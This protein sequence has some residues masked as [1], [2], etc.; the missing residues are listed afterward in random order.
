MLALLRAKM[1]SCLLLAML[2]LFLSKLLDLSDTVVLLE[3]PNRRRWRR[4]GL[5]IHNLRVPQSLLKLG[6]AR[7][8]SIAA[9]VT[10]SGILSWCVVVPATANA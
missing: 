3:L 7:V 9:I 1:C 10:W 4:V 2:R 5:R 6:T 8:G